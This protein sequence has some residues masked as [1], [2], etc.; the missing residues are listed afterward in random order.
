MINENRSLL[1]YILLTIV[2][3]G[4]Y[5]FIFIYTMAQDVNQMCDGDGESTSGLLVFILLSYVTCGFYA[6][7]WYYKL[8]NRLEANAG[9]YG[10]HFDEN[11]TT[12]LLWCVVGMIACG[13]GQF[14]AMYLLIKNTNALAHAYNQG[15]KTINY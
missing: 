11:G 14:F 7:Y 5:G 4:I 2:T 10:L 9:R 3:C 12:I 15:G 13:L 1:T 6:F 8:G